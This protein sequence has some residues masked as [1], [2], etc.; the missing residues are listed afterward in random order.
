MTVTRQTSKHKPAGRRDAELLAEWL[1]QM[2]EQVKKEKDLPTMFHEAELVFKSCFEELVSQVSVQCSE[3]GSLLSK[4]WGA[5]IGLLERSLIQLKQEKL[6]DNLELKGLMQT[7]QQSHSAQ[8]ASL[9]DQLAVIQKEKEDIEAENRVRVRA[10]QLHMQR[11]RKLTSR[12]EIIQKYYEDNKSE[13]LTLKEKYRVTRIELENQVSDYSEDEAG[14]IVKTKRVK[15][16]KQKD[17]H[18][19]KRDVMLHPAAQKELTDSIEKEI[20][21]YDAQLEIKYDDDDFKDKSTDTSDFVKCTVGVETTLEDCGGYAVGERGPFKKQR[22]VQT[23]VKDLCGTSEGVTKTKSHLNSMSMAISKAIVVPQSTEETEA[24]SVSDINTVPA[25][26]EALIKQIQAKFP[27][28]DSVKEMILAF[29]RR[30]ISHHRLSESQSFLDDS[31]EEQEAFGSTAEIKGK[32]GKKNYTEI[33]AFRLGKRKNTGRH[34]AEPHI[35]L[36]QK[37][38]STPV[39]AIKN[40]TIKKMLLKTITG[41]YEE[42]LMNAKD[43]ADFEG[44]LVQIVYKLCKNKYGFKAAEQKFTQI[45]GSC[46]KFRE[47]LRIETFGRFM[48]LYDPLDSGALG[49]YLKGLDFIKSSKLGKDRPWVDYEENHMTPYKRA[50]DC[51]RALF[52]SYQSY[53]EVASNLQKLRVNDPTGANKHGEIEA[54]HFLRFLVDA[55]CAEKSRVRVFV[56]RVFEAADLNGDSFL[57]YEEYEILVKYLSPLG[58]A[59]DLFDQ[60]ADIHTEEG[61]E[62]IT[63]ENFLQL[64]KTNPS[65]FPENQLYSFAGLTSDSEAEAQLEGVRSRLDFTIQQL[66][67][68]WP[69]IDMETLDC[70][71]VK[72]LQPDDPFSVWLGLRLLEEE[73]KRSKVDR[74]LATMLP[75]LVSRD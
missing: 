19:I 28:P 56:K 30:A 3:R 37:V 44:D 45:I 75:G 21:H 54:E 51:L 67:W 10:Q 12:L 18:E 73:S 25:E 64:V 1:D 52:E 15:R 65:I 17:R 68:R 7:Q 2:L 38:L 59:R 11:E 70:L 9:Q 35:I 14:Q 8:L 72:I 6:K 22:R 13:L 27:I 32:Q 47:C 39:H 41:F 74:V 55:Y 62:A 5:Y 48:G 29:G 71:T 34:R 33:M 60:F 43:S 58:E 46:L 66:Q 4:V 61:L 20:E 40:V 53:L 42:F 31:D 26:S 63:F 23:D 57:E 24:A 69:D 49:L 50:E 16:F 36:V